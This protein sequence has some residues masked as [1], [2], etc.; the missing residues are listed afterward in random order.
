MSGGETLTVLHV[1]RVW[2]F[3]KQERIKS[4]PVFIAG[5]IFANGKSHLALPWTRSLHSLLRARRVKVDALHACE[6]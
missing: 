6:S 2:D 5:D 3:M 1:P 4:N